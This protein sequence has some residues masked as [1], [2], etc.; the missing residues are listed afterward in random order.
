VIDQNLARGLFL[1]L[2]AL[3][4]GLQALTYRMGDVSAI[5]P[6][7]F[8]LVVSSFLLVVGVAT[9]IRAHFTERVPFEFTVK[10]VGL[11]V[12]SL[13]IFALL[14]EYVN[15]LLGI[16]VM[17]FCA[18]VAGTSYSIVRNIQI[19]VVLIAI[20]LAFQKLLGLDLPLY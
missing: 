3:F 17:V 2:I 20:A 6:G 19:A 7:S 5:G 18:S 14:S 9:I 13:I 1:V 15:M 10:N 12:A 16:V 11:I 4:F 8:P